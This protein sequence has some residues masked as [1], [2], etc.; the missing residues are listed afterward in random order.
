MII[1][2]VHIFITN[3]VCVATLTWNN[4]TGYCSNHRWK[5]ARLFSGC[6][7]RIDIL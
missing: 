5:W 3:L 1:F 7:Q 4:H 6:S 2:I